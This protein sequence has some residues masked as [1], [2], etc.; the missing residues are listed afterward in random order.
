MHK[1]IEYV[2]QR[3]KG[4]K[5]TNG[6]KDDPV[7]LKAKTLDK[8][9][10]CRYW[11]DVKGWEGIGKSCVAHNTNNHPKKHQHP[12]PGLPCAN[13]GSMDLSC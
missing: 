9:K 1:L 11:Q 5:E 12:M 2:P 13:C 4:R 7:V 10:Q 3:E 8:P 6:T